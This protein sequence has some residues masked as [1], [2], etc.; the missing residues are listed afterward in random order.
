MPKGPHWSLPALSSSSQETK[1]TAPQKR[2]THVW[3]AGASKVCK[4]FI[5]QSESGWHLAI[6]AEIRKNFRVFVVLASFSP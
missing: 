4:T 2:I 6:N 1:K 5:L 3:S